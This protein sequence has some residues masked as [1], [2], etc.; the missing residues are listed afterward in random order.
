MKT[1]MSVSE[2]VMEN[3]NAWRN[4]QQT[5]EGV[6]NIWRVMKECIYKGCHT[7]GYLP[8]GL[9]VKRRAFSLNEKLLG[10][11]TYHDFDSWIEAIRAG[12]NHFQYTLDW[13]SCFALA[14]NEENASFGRVVTAPTNGAAGVIPAVLQYFVVFCNGN[15]P[16]QVLK[17]ML[18]A[19]EIGSIFKKGSTI[20]AAM[21]GCQA[22]IGVSSAMAAAALTEC[23]GGTQRQVLMA[24]EIAME[25]HLGLTCDPIAG[26]VQVPCIE[27]NTMGAIKAI[28]AS[29]LALQSTPDF[30]KVSLDAVVKTMWDTAKDMNH[31]YKE[32]AEGGLA[33]NI[34]ISLSEC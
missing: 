13:V 22:E 5:K 16:E 27:R 3:E 1:G 10:G 30:A 21:G 31:K 14:V 26:L 7:E 6:L 18:T 20:S 33:I 19:S 32:T 25:H 11:R 23:L 17:F 9:N 2:I 34:P 28:T 24:A 15:F 12:G 8:G 29:Q 4:E